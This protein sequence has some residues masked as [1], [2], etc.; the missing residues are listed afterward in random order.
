M[1]AY[2]FWLQNIVK[3]VIYLAENC[4]S[5]L[6][7]IDK[8]NSM[9]TMQIHPKCY[10]LMCTFLWYFMC[11]YVRPSKKDYCTHNPLKCACKLPVL[12]LK[13]SIGKSELLLYYANRNACFFFSFIHF[14]FAYYEDLIVLS[15]EFDQ[16]PISFPVKLIA[17]YCQTDA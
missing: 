9:I 1:V 11:W 2:Y 3:S 7:L 4:F 17:K 8:D 6:R 16:I 5:W 13:G 14:C 10:L 12:V 15:T